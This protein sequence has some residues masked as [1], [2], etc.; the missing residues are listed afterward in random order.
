MLDHC[1]ALYEVFKRENNKEN[2]NIGTNQNFKNIEIA[3]K[4]IKLSKKI[5]IYNN[6]SKISFV[7]DRPGHDFRYA[8]NSKKIKKKLKWKF[9]IKINEG[10]ITTFKWY[11]ENK[12][13]FT[14]VK[15]KDFVNRIGNKR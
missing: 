6:K 12:N 14:S 7:K 15:N 10:L 8:L 3:S 11:L 2:Y 4:L 1:R 13:F 5:G 9:K